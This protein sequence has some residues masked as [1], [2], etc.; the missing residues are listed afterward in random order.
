MFF[1]SYS[2][3]STCPANVTT[4]NKHRAR[5]DVR[6]YNRFRRLKNNSL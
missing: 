1:S 3:N 2:G 6:W 5:T 4:A